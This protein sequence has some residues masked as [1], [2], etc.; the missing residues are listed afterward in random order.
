MYSER[1]KIAIMMQDKIKS[2]RNAVLSAIDSST[3]IDEN[4][5]ILF[6]DLINNAADGTNGLGQEEKLQNVSET[7]FSLVMLKILDKCAAPDVKKRYSLY[8]MIAECK[9]AI[10][11]LGGIVSIALIMRPELSSLITAIFS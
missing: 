7:V 11:V 1:R 8:S 9:W 2:N 10:C 4:D 3:H 6:R 5:K